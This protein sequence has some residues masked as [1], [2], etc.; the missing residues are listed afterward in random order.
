MKHEKAIKTLLILDSLRGTDSTGVAV[1]SR[2]GEVKV[3]KELG[4]PFRLFDNKRFDKAFSGM[5][6]VAIGHNR[7]ATQGKVNVRNAHPFEFDELVGAHNGTL[8]NKHV[9]VDSRDFEVDSENLYH[10]IAK[11]GLRDAIDPLDGA[12]AL[13][14]W[15]KKDSTLNFL[16]NEER[17]LWFAKEKTTNV[18]FW[19]S[20]KWMLSVALSRH[21]IQFD[22]PF[23]LE[24]DKHVCMTMYEDGTHEKPIITPMKSSFVAPVFVNNNVYRYQPP[25]QQQQ[26]QLPLNKEE[27]KKADPKS[28]VLTPSPFKSGK[29]YTFEVI[30]EGVDQAGSS[31]YMCRNRVHSNESVRLYKTRS[32][33]VS[34]LSKFISAEVHMFRYT[35]RT[36]AYHK[37]EHGS[38]RI[39]Q[40]ETE[41][42]GSETSNG[43]YFTDAL[44]KLISKKDWIKKHGTC[45][46]CTGFV[47]PE[48]KHRF[49]AS[50]DSLCEVCSDD[51]EIRRYVH[52]L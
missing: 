26:K 31:Y 24:V 38:V 19:A 20:E 49:T 34:L 47:D 16:R 10:H 32:D 18:F 27:P 52:V 45:G 33:K 35:D 29:E 46:W 48:H 13:V 44:G 39:V 43:A 14:W 8:R 21:D 17:P 9:L 51:P 2:Q 36:G 50:N 4:D 7:F 6:C 40:D 3:A 30:G 23:E 37:V 1:V 5:N 25:A 28:S 12:W 15:D 22:D 42:E 41:G 11:K